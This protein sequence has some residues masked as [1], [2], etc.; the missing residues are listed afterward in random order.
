MSGGPFTDSAT[1]FSFPKYTSVPHRGT[2]LGRRHDRDEWV[3][4]L[5]L[6]YCCV[7]GGVAGTGGLGE[8]LAADLG[9]EDGAVVFGGR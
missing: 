3:A 7:G 1:H 6:G 8:L 4:C 9:G 5:R 2:P